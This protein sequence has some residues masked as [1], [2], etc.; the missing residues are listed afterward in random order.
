MIPC[1]A[2]RLEESTSYHF[3]QREG[4]DDYRSCEDLFDRSTFLGAF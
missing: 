2:L 3:N 1:Y 4:R